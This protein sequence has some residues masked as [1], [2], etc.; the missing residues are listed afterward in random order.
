MMKKTITALFTISAISL[1]NISAYAHT[2]D[3]SDWAKESYKKV[4]E[5]GAISD[6]LY[7]ANP[8]ASITRHDFAELI[9]HAYNA[10]NNTEYIPDTIHEFND[11][12]NADECISAMYALGIM[13][14]NEN[15]EFHP[16]NNITRQETA[17]VISNF[18]SVLNNDT[19]KPDLDIL[20]E[21]NDI[22]KIADW[23]R[24]AVS[25][26]TNAG[27]MSTYGDN[28][29]H[30]WDDVSIEQA[31]SIVSRMIGDTNE[32]APV[33]TEPPAP[34]ELSGNLDVSC[35]ETPNFMNIEWNEIENASEYTV[36]I[37]QRRNHRRSDEIE[38]LTS[39]YTTT[40]TFMSIPSAPGRTYDI[41]V[42]TGNL[43]DSTQL[44]TL[45]SYNDTDWYTLPETQEDAETMMQEIEI[46]IWKMNSSGE[47]Y[48]STTSLKVHKDIAD[49]VYLIFQEIF[50]GDEQ[51]PIE[52]VGAYSWRGGRSE[53]NW[54]TAIDINPTQNYCIYKSG[55]IVGD[56]WA[57]YEDPRSITPYGDVINA[58]ENHGFTWGGDAWS[59]NIDYM[60]F[61]YFGT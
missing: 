39:V 29:F 3:V 33:P 41:T 44:K 22:T 61:S 36:T 20:N 2:I 54:G 11:I 58:F 38:P 9:L 60:H 13:Q 34:I 5:M 30:P 16:K 8:T 23:S 43:S 17:M 57:P 19:L 10:H 28:E 4:I 6:N 40:D 14:G 52:S 46:N 53:H 35:N 55:Q 7:N 59:G 32:P 37:T 1:F 49:I 21:F 12:D 47:K 24:E 15:N 31:V 26:V 42:K 45:S 50:E 48:A 18:Y 51:F 25:A 56:Y 27:F